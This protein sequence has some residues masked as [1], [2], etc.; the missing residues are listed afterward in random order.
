MMVAGSCEVAGS[1]RWP[2]EGDE[3]EQIDSKRVRALDWCKRQ[4]LVTRLTEVGGD[5]VERGN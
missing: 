1:C 4:G 5:E 2:V 3:A